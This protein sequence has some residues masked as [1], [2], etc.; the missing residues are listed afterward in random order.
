M[1]PDNLRVPLSKLLLDQ[2]RPDLDV[3]HCRHYLRDFGFEVLM[4]TVE[5][6]CSLDLHVILLQVA[7]VLEGLKFSL[8]AVKIIVTE[9]SFSGVFG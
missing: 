1:P 8:P 4:K 2:I 3:G 6:H 7:H 5:Q 9:F